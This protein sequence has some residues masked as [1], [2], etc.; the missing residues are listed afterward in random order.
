V[1]NTQGVRAI[2]GVPADI[3]AG[4]IECVVEDIGVDAIK[5]GMLH[6][7]ATVE[8]VAGA[9]QNVARTV[10]VILDPVMVATSGDTL[11]ASDAIESFKTHM[12]P[13][14]TLLTPN[15]PELALLSGQSVES[16]QEREQAARS[17]APL[18]KASILVKGGHDS[19]PQLIDLLLD[20]DRIEQF[21]GERLFSN[22]THGTGC[23]LA[24]AIACH[25]GAGVP[26]GEAVRK[27]RSYVYKAIQTAP[28]FGQ[29]AGPLNHL[30]PLQS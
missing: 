17:L 5:I 7:V 15:L 8:A 3:I 13:L 1:Q 2:H 26:L 29:G 21:K 14:A 6:D 4:Q 22:N 23:T 25:R 12:L 9:L 16:L 11:L 27:A 28:G 20:N 10:P 24:S 18:T 30:H 19:G